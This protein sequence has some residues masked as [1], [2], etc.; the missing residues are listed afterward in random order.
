[1]VDTA[2][3]LR[4]LT[5]MPGV[6]ADAG[7]EMSLLAT[8]PLLIGHG[9]DLH[10][11]VLTPRQDLVPRLERSGVVVHDLSA[12]HGVP[13]WTRGL[14]RTIRDLRPDL[15][16]AT[17]WEA[18]VSAQLAARITGVPVLETWA[19]T[20]RDHSGE[21][22]AS[23]WKLRLVTATEY[24]AG[25]VS[26]SRYHAVTQGVADDNARLLRV[27]PDRIRVAERGR[28]P[29]R[30]RPRSAAE[31]D[32]LRDSLGLA[33]GDRL[34]LAVG[35]QEPTKAHERLL[36]TVD[37]LVDRDPSVVVAIAGREGSATPMLEQRRAALRHR[38]R[39]LFLGNRD[40]VPALLQ[41]A[42][43]IVCTSTREGAAGALIEAMASG[44]P[45][46]S[47]PV[48]GLADVLVDDGNALVV[49]VDGLGPAIS[50]VLGDPDLAGRLTAVARADFDRR[51][52]SERSAEALL[53]VYRWA[54]R[55]NPAAPP[56]ATPAGP[57]RAGAAASDGPRR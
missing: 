25:A 38:D 1:M 27:P 5:V 15:V 23:G 45:I 52:T 26:R 41:V 16:H 48:T 40:D 4:V 44:C 2:R 13:S 49:D 34:V 46:V 35:R 55:R 20:T 8:A 56:S 47:V 33:A 22:V 29:E 11:A 18:A 10:L 28:D 12:R 24:L 31:L 32:A 57:G 42:G 3:P 30:F 21:G 36:A 50:R 43:C 54:A 53:E 51:F 7:A 14:V 6:T 37:D 39:V 9:V 17:L 19:N